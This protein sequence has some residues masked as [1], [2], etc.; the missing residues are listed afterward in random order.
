MYDIYIWDISGNCENIPQPLP[1]NLKNYKLHDIEIRYGL[2]QLGEGLAFLHGDVKLLHRNLC[3]ES[4]V[5]NI[6]GA[7]KIFGFDFCALNQ[8]SDSKQVCEDN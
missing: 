4:I 8:S 7:W 2:L 5:I 3:P 1:A 6:H